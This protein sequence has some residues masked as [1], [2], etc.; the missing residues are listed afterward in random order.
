MT[1]PQLKNFLVLAE[2]LNFRQAA[3]QILIAQPALSRQIQQLEEEIGS[4][5]FARNS[6]NVELTKSGV[7]FRSEVD[8][9]LGQLEYACQRA[10]ALEKGVV[11]T[12]R[13]GHASSTMQSVLPGLIKNLHESLPGLK[14]VLYEIT[15]RQQM[16]M[17]R[18]REIDFGFMPNTFV[19]EDLRSRVVYREPFTLILPQNHRLNAQ[20]FKSLRDLKDET[21][22]LPQRHEGHG[23]VENVENIFQAYGFTPNV[24][25][26]TPNAASVLRLVEAGLGV[27]VMGRST[28]KGVSLAI[29]G[30]DLP[31]FPLQV[32]KKL[33]WLG[34][35]EEELMDYLNLFDRLLSNV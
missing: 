21:F 9:L 35:R 7:Y 28:L 20:N 24:G 27:S 17:L 34:E 1:I 26:E 25:Y 16:D 32:E 29:K 15:N 22:I 2:T 8:R 3:E 33:A 11:G 12:L 14:I 19:P 23:Y 6:R 5:L 31:D 13:I 18:H 30:L 4:Q 10:V